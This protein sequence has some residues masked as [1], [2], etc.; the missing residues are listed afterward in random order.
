Y[1]GAQFALWFDG[2]ILGVTES[3]SPWAW[4]FPCPRTQNVIGTFPIHVC[5]GA[6]KVEV[7]EIT[8]HIIPWMLAGPNS[9]LAISVGMDVDATRYHGN[10]P[11]IPTASS[12][13]TIAG[14]SYP[15]PSSGIQKIAFRSPEGATGS[16]SLEIFNVRGTKIRA[17]TVSPVSGTEHS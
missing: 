3:V 17:L 9:M 5:G 14:T 6:H 10:S 12:P 4:G 2:Q 11:L 7:Q 16:P 8:M 15:N 1:P 13:A